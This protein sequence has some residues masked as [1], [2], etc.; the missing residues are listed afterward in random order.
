MKLT[1]RLLDSG[2][3][4][5]EHQ[6]LLG[7]DAKRVADFSL[8]ATACAALATIPAVFFHASQSQ[9]LRVLGD[10]LGIVIWLI[11]V[12]ETLV[13]IRLHSGW[14]IEWLKSHKLQLTVIFLANPLLIWAIGRFEALELFPLLPLPSFLQSAKIM[15][16]FK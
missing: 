6:T 14:G 8:T 3:T 16:I 7:L 9:S 12:A 15:K 2:L 4:D 1:F 5:P 13:M 11:F 10:V